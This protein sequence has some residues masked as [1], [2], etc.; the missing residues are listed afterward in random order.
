MLADQGIAST[1]RAKSRSFV[2]LMTLYE[3]NFIRLGW[4]I[5]DFKA[6]ARESRSRSVSD[7]DLH[8]TLLERNPY[9]SLLRLTY[10]FGDAEQCVA[11]PALELCVYHDARLAEARAVSGE[12][13]HP[14]LRQ[15]RAEVKRELDQRWA[16]NIML[17]K[18]LEYCAERGHCF[19]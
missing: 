17:N 14:L 16:R 7:C 9:T 6:L 5:P 8:L 19:V 3:S 13:R 10:L 15:A 2:A 1:W 4:L 18:W 12:C 11:E